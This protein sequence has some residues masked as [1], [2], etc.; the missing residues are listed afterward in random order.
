MLELQTQWQLEKL[1]E[2]GSLCTIT[3]DRRWS[4][5]EGHSNILT[6]RCTVQYEATMLWN[7]IEEILSVRF[8]TL[9]T[10][11]L[12]RDFKSLNS[13][14]DN[15]SRTGN[16]ETHSQVSL[17]NPSL[18][19]P[20]ILTAIRIPCRRL[21]VRYQQVCG[22]AMIGALNEAFFA[23]LSVG[24]H[25]N[26]QGHD[27]PWVSNHDTSLSAQTQTGSYFQLFLSARQDFQ[28]L[29]ILLIR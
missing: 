21:T 3:S 10:I 1:S 5:S 23:R 9:D 14:A 6:W 16:F 27:R 11:A 29:C 26:G 7:P 24:V 17:P 28:I 13:Q 18:I 25:V 20:R 12:T 22:P 8:N 15:C 4:I 2:D 19:G